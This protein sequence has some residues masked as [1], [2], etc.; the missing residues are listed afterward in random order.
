MI[1]RI[2]DWLVYGAIVLLIYLNATRTADRQHAPQPPP[3]QDIGPLLPTDSPFDTTVLV[4][5]GEP[6]SAIGTAFAVDN[7]GT[8]LTARH[9]VDECDEVA[10]KIG[11]SKIIRVQSRINPKSDTAILSSNWSR[12]A[13]ATDL[14]SDRHIGEN[15]FFFG[16]PQGKP[17]EAAATLLGRHKMIVRG[18][19]QTEEPI[20]AWSEIGRTRGLNG[21]LGGMSGGPVFDTDGE[22]IGL[23]AAESPRRGR[24]YSVAPR[25]L[26]DLVP[27]NEEASAIP[28]AVTN[29]G[30]EADRYRRTRQIAQV[31]CLVDN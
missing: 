29:Y 19:Y 20:L 3:P 5:M 18:R 7:N 24:I 27:P 11:Y 28:I 21:S 1:R 22:V 17:G 16:F 25:N 26:R 31:H 23:V 30:T 10:L 9:V 13:L 2:P 8:W 14:Y 15:G 12:K 4:E 6:H